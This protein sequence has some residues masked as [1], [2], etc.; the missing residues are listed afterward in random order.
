[1]IRGVIRPASLLLAAC[2]VFSVL[3]AGPAAAQP[4]VGLRGGAS[5]DP[6]QAF[7]GVHVETRPLIEHLTFRPNLELGVGDDLTL[8][9]LN[10]E[11]AY[12]IPLE[13]TQWRLYLGGGPAINI[14][15]FDEGPGRAGDTDVEGGF[16]IL[17]GLQHRRGLF[18]ELKVGAMDSPDLKFTIGY[19]FGR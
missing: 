4:S 8:V 18:G 15:S 12:W 17:L 3:S 16:N 6:D 2:S 14:Y 13:R 11:F 7:F 19:V 1:M 5:V 10:F 9:A